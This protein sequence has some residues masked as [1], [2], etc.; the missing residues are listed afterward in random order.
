ME[1]TTREL[2]DTIINSELTNEQ[3]T[4]IL[5]RLVT[6]GKITEG[7]Y[8][9]K[10]RHNKLECWFRNLDESGTAYHGPTNYSKEQVVEIYSNSIN[11][12]ESIKI[13]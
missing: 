11:K 7:F 4:D 1:F 8:L 10:N 12:E 2:I 13:H 6:S 3:K 5:E 9:R